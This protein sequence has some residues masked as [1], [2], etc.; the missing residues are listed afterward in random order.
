MTCASQYHKRG[1]IVPDLYYYGKKFIH[2][3]K[4]P[5]QPTGMA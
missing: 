3:M 5:K 1:T 4:K 2:L